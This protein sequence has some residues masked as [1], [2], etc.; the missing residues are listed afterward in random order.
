MRGRILNQQIP[1]IRELLTGNPLTGKVGPREVFD[2]MAINPGTRH[3]VPIWIGGQ[4]KAARERA[5]FLGEGWMPLGDVDQYMQQ[6]GYLHEQL[7]IVGKK[8]R[9]FSTMGRI[10]LGKTPSSLWVDNFLSWQRAGA[11]HVALT[12]TGN[13]S[14]YDQ[15]GIMADPHHHLQL[16][17]R[18]L[19]LTDWLRTPRFG[20]LSSF[21]RSQGRQEFL[22]DLPAKLQD[23]LYLE[24]DEDLKIEYIAQFL[25]ERANFVWATTSETFQLQVKKTGESL[26]NQPRYLIGPDG[27]KVHF[28][29]SLD[30]TNKLYVMYD[31][32][33]ELGFNIW[34]P[35]W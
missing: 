11:T 27:L 35:V 32:V 4:S 18:F 17:N 23:C 8:P 34:K 22:E 16:Q 3:K 28:F 24:L 9:D 30:G 25:A 19:E 31:Q 21:F 14:E 15:N 10:A 1:A 29:H 13:E 20:T 5:A 6:I 26:Q 12:T 7:S 2:Q 33:L